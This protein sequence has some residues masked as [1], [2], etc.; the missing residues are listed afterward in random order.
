MSEYRNILHSFWMDL[1]RGR[2]GGVRARLGLLGDNGKPSDGELTGYGR[3]EVSALLAVVE[4]F[5]RSG[6]EIRE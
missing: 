4:E 3:D 6:Y 5:A 1:K 2:N